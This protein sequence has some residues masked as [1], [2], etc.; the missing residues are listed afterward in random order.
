MRLVDVFGAS[1]K[2]SFAAA[3]ESNRIE[4]AV[5]GPDRRRL[6]IL[7]D[8]TR[9]R[10]LAF[11]P[12]V[13][14]TVSNE[15]VDTG[16]APKHLNRVIPTDGQRVA[17][18]SGDPNFQVRTN[19]LDAGSYGRRT[20]MNRMETKCVHVIREAAGAADTGNNHE[21][22]ALDAQLWKDGLHRG[23]NRVVSA[24]RAPAHFLVGLKIFFRERR[25]QRRGA[26]RRFS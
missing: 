26:H 17:V 3:A 18:A 8:F 1:H 10:A 25:W 4:G 16:R 7:V 11:R 2:S 9:R 15:N 24:A 6:R 5:H 23:E 20:T 14:P 22:L 21:V 12:T 13:E 19:S